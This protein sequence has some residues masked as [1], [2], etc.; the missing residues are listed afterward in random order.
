LTLD[1]YGGYKAYRLEMT[2]DG[3]TKSKSKEKVIE[4]HIPL[5]DKK[6]ERTYVN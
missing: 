3:A 2:S 4:K 1:G 5:E 6:E